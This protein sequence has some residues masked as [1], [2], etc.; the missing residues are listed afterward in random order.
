MRTN[1]N[2][3]GENKVFNYLIEY[4]DGVGIEYS[5]R[6]FLYKLNENKFTLCI[7]EP[8]F[9]RDINTWGKLEDM[10]LE[11]EANINYYPESYSIGYI[12]LY[13]PTYSLDIYKPGSNYAITISIKIGN[14]DIILGSQ[15]INRM[16]ALATP[17]KR[18]FGQD[19]LEG[20]QIPIVNPFDLIYDTNWSNFRQHI[21]GKSL[22][23][24]NDITSL[25]HISLQPVDSKDDI[26]IKS[27][28]YIGGQ[29]SLPISNNN[30]LR[31]HIDTNINN[32]LQDEIPSIVCNALFNE[33][34]ANL[35]SYL[36]STYGLTGYKAKY[37]IVIGNETDIYFIGEKVSQSGEVSFDKSEITD[38]G[39]FSNWNGWKEGI[40]II[41]S[42]D[43]LDENDNN[44]LYILSNKLPF[45]QNIY[46]F[47]V[48]NESNITLNSVNLDSIQM[49]LINISATNKIEN[50]IIKTQVMGESKNHLIQ[51]I[52]F[53][54]VE[55]SNIIIHPKITETICINLDIYKSKIDRFVIQIDGVN[56]N[57][58]GRTPAG[59]LFKI[60]HNKLSGNNQSGN[61]Y[62]LNTENELITSG[63][64]TYA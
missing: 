15:V 60:Y 63:K 11:Y 16:D 18:V 45:S 38:G 47:F 22:I 39:N 52:F 25:L 54:S 1:I 5:N 4:T 42:I 23:E 20:I 57:E 51:P 7:N 30:Y 27:N 26:Y 29:N 50:K 34:F 17:H 10:L 61:Y 56:F 37:K 40:F 33:K 41:G 32:Y 46:K 14:A 13:F 24:K 53:R 9:I 64:Y 8:E 35:G 43:I 58:I 21:C 6:P 44:I 28:T 31:L 62:I 36:R 2:I 55:S 3:S 19:Y 48:N 59:I 49:N 12:T